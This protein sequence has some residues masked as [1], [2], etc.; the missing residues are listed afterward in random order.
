MDG[1]IHFRRHLLQSIL[2]E[3]QPAFCGSPDLRS[4]SSDLKNGSAD[5]DLIEAA[6]IVVTVQDVNSVHKKEAQDKGRGA[7]DET[8]AEASS[9]GTYIHLH[10]C[11]H[12][13]IHVLV[14]L[15]S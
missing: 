14:Q 13:H 15:L 3:Q 9:E 1:F 4:A 10:A 12:L 8:E 5:P 7:D 2:A 6:G 11:I